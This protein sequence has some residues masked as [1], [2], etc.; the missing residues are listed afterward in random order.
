MNHSYLLQNI[1]EK[2]IINSIKEAD[3]NLVKNLLN[4]NTVIE[5][6]KDVLSKPELLKKFVI[7]PIHM[8]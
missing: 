3:M 8:L 2:Y 7:D 6:L 1:K 5:L 4:R